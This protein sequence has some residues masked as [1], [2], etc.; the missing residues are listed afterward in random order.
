M[1]KEEE[2]LYTK[3]LY[4]LSHTA[5]APLLEGTT[6]PW[7]A[8]PQIGAFIRELGAGL[9]LEEYDHPQEDVWIHKTAKIYP[10]NFIAGPC[11]IG[12]G[13][14]VRPGAFIRGN[15][16]VGEN[17]VVGN[18]TELKNVILF[19]S[20]QVPH[21]N[22][23]GDSILGYK[24]H[25]GAGSITSNVKSDKLLV[26]IHAEDGEIETGRKKVGAMLGDQVEVGC[27][28][29]LN[30][31]TVIGRESNIYPLSSVRGC[32]NAR[33]IYKRQG[34]VAEKREQ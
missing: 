31:G 13:T 2:K 4:D 12:A 8:L 5:A 29:V 7:E 6:Y 10:N 32:V 14:E 9:S 33:S 26:K 22:Y 20:V 16:L 21:Y 17:C 28:S 30:P 24:S 25:M 11:V 19:D 3:E 15:A 34:E 27:G 1:M 18:S 23:V